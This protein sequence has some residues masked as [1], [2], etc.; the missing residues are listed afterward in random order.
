M[1]TMYA[2]KDGQ[3]PSRFMAAG[4]PVVEEAFLSDNRYLTDLVQPRLSF[5]NPYQHGFINTG[6]MFKE[7]DKYMR[8]K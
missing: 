7:M 6:R 5:L 3:V 8:D 2:C 4:E 1:I